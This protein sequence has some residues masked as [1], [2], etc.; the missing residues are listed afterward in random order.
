MA[1]SFPNQHPW[2]PH[3]EVVGVRGTSAHPGA[4]CW[5]LP[6]ASVFR[7]PV[8]NEQPSVPRDMWSQWLFQSKNGRLSQAAP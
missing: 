1:S 7:G 5:H 2:P 8:R 4:M 3:H 6:E